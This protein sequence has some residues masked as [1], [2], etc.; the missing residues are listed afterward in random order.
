MPRAMSSA[1]M[2]NCELHHRPEERAGIAAGKPLYVIRIDSEENS[3][4]VGTQDEAVNRVVRAEEVNVLIPDELYQ[5][6]HLYGKIRSQG[7][8]TE[9]TI[10]ETDGS[11]I[12]VEFDSP[13]FAPPGQ[14]PDWTTL[15]AAWSPVRLLHFRRI[16]WMRSNRNE[17]GKN[18]HFQGRNNEHDYQ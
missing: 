9:C 6:A 13:Q 2:G 18:G 16:A 8:P 12:Q 14:R 11:K 17:N 3:V 4:T 1:S 5:K 10:L 15:T 7:E